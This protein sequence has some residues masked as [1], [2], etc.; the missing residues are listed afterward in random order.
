MRTLPKRLRIN[1]HGSV[2]NFVFK[3]G[4]THNQL[5][6]YRFCWPKVESCHYALRVPV[7]RDRLYCA[8]SGSTEPLR[9]L[10]P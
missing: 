3:S 10:I 2:I 6:L 1:A 9:I 4:L 5:I 7:W 8:A